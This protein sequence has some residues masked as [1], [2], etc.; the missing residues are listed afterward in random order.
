MFTF[1]G[2]GSGSEEEDDDDEEIGEDGVARLKKHKKKGIIFV[3]KGFE[4]VFPS[5]A[6]FTKNNSFFLRKLT[7]GMNF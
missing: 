7:S 1:T 3:F 4:V 6:K 5:F 2:K